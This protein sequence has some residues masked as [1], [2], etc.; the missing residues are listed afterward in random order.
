[1]G[2]GK[3]GWGRAQCKPEQRRRQP[4]GMARPPENRTP[5]AE[6]F[7]CARRARVS[8]IPTREQKMSGMLTATERAR[9]RA[10]VVVLTIHAKRKRLELAVPVLPGRFCPLL[11]GFK[12][13][14]QRREEGDCAGAACSM[15]VIASGKVVEK[16]GLVTKAQPIGGS[17]GLEKRAHSNGHAPCSCYSW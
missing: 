16:H 13:E 8:S 1:M 7:G 4:A 14:M 17:G 12:A 10:R 15:C 5:H 11:R 9:G 2:Q 3:Q 6:D